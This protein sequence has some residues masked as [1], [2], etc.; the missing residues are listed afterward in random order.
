[1]ARI[2]WRSP[3]NSNAKQCTRTNRPEQ[4]K[5]T[6]SLIGFFNR[7]RRSEREKLAQ[8]VPPVK[9]RTHSANT[10]IHA[11]GEKEN[12]LEGGQ[13]FYEGSIIHRPCFCFRCFNYRSILIPQHEASVNN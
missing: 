4:K 11:V 7:A 2:P 13:C 3:S 1:M 8:A 5:T 10:P 12:L 9:T 6:A